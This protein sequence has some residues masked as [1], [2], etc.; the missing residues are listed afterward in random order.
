MGP[1]RA[2]GP[3]PITDGM[4][5]GALDVVLVGPTMY[6][7][8]TSFIDLTRLLRTVETDAVTGYVRVHGPDHGALVLLVG[9][10]IVAARYDDDAVGAVSDLRGALRCLH[11]RAGCEDGRVTVVELD[12]DRAE[13]ATEMLAGRTL[14]SGLLGR[15]AD[16]DGL[17]DHLGE[18]A[19]DACLVVHAPGGTAVVLFAGG[20]VRCTFLRRRSV[21][22]RVPATV[23]ALAAEAAA[24]IEVAVDVHW[25]PGRSQVPRLVLQGR[26]GEDT[27]WR[28]SLTAAGGGA[29]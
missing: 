4:V 8:P 21:S 10:R 6:T 23:R 2:V 12:A 25:V 14:V 24:R 16:L 3:V 18:V 22:G 26:R 1:E 13:A 11:R 9:G 5:G 7:G 29:A 17:L 28:S 27:R 15:F 20:L 19:A